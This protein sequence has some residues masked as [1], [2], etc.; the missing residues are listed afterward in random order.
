MVTMPGS[1]G[2]LAAFVAEAAITFSMLLW[3]FARLPVIAFGLT[4]ASSA[5][6]GWRCSSCLSRPSR[7]RV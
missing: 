7:V 2:W 3:S 5:G 1:W 4:Q 6:V